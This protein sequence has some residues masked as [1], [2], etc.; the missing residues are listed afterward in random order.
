MIEFFVILICLILNAVLSATETAFVSTQKNILRQLNQI[1]HG[2]VT[3][4][5]KLRESPERTLAVI[6]I[7]IT[8][9]GILS[10]VVGGA[11][12][13]EELS[14]RLQT[15]FGLA[16]STSEAICIVLVVIPL[17]FFTVIFGELVPKTL[18]L[19]NPLKI[20]MAASRWLYFLDKAFQPLVDS[21]E[22]ITK[23][24][25]N[26]RSVF[27]KL[28]QPVQLPDGETSEKGLSKQH[29]EF[30]FN[31]VNLESKILGD[32]FIPWEN[33]DS[34]DLEQSAEEVLDKSIR[35]GHTRLPVNTLGQPTAM[36]NTKEL[37][38]FISEGGKDWPLIIRPVLRLNKSD[39]LI[40]ALKLMQQQHSQM[41]LIETSD[42]KVIGVVTLEEIIEEIVGDIFDEDDDHAIQKL[43]ADK[44]KL[45]KT[46]L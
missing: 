36:L 10:G 31:L 28:P 34:V 44:L 40:K 11:G 45:K 30:I 5:L 35:S 33:V 43:L 8:L 23:K 27:S 3:R 18:A 19:R 20:S 17:T 37:L 4:L 29:Q 16:P 12:I 1:W 24:I 22:W 46:R 9:V 42:H 2:K 13:E 15:Y 21:F 26:W 41:A 7:G 6:Q 38:I 39:S 32:I 25:V 14:P